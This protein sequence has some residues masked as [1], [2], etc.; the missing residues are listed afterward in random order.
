MT[1]SKDDKRI[2][3][4]LRAW[5]DEERRAAASE[6]MASYHRDGLIPAQ[7]HSDERRAHTSQ[8]MKEVWAKRHA[9][10]EKSCL[11]PG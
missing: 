1:N 7:V 2:E 4:L 9:E 5:D 8:K 11:E 10:A 3:G 6:R